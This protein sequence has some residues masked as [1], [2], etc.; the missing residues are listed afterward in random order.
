MGEPF[1]YSLRVR[2]A[3]CDVQGIVFNAHYLA[4]FDVSMTELWREAFGG[5]RAML[6]K[7][8]DMVLADAQ[9]RYL[10][11]ARF[12]DELKLGVSVTRLGTTS[13]IT[14]HHVWRGLELL[15][16]GTLRHVFVN[17]KTLQKTPIPAWATAGLAPWVVEQEP[18]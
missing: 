18:D 3:E 9:L 2:Y 4:Y 6:E 13:V 14:R 16:E 15:V 17:L 10:S 7:G 8:V 11:P 12:D 5:Y 1:E